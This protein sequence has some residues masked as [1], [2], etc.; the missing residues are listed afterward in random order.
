MSG[1]T[2]PPA[3]D[4]TE[5]LKREETDRRLVR[6]C[7]SFWDL[8]G[9][10]KATVNAG[11]R[12]GRVQSARLQQKEPEKVGAEGDAIA[13]EGSDEPDGWVWRLREANFQRER[14]RDGPRSSL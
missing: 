9:R 11:K 5:D 12:V 8:Y 1:D 3:P 13:I 7:A 6:G 10:L 14:E 2:E 4:G